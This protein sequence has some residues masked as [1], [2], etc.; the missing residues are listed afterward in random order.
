MGENV[1]G[2]PSGAVPCNLST[3]ALGTN[4]LGNITHARGSQLLGMTDC[5]Q[6]GGGSATSQL[7]A[8]HRDL[9]NHRKTYAEALRGSS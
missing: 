8:Q 7:S 6:H 2:Q 5:P 4:I 3:V 9:G 1:T